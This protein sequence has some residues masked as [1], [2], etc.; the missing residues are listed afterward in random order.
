MSDNLVGV[1]TVV[2][3]DLWKHIGKD[4]PK[5]A[6]SA[7]KLSA[8]DLPPM[9]RTGLTTLYSH[10]TGEFERWERA[11][12]GVPPVFIVVCQNTA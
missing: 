3:L 7:A 9:L 2:Y 4:L 6:A 8:F 11:G 1:D 10:Y 5:A 12:I